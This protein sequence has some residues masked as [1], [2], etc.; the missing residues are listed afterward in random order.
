MAW[1]MLPTAKT[2]N[3]RFIASTVQKRK[4]N[5]VV[6]P[7]ALFALRFLQV[8]LAVFSFFAAGAAKNHLL[9]SKSKIGVRHSSR[10]MVFG[11]AGWLH[12]RR[13]CDFIQAIEN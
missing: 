8:D 1:R 7:A 6:G 10:S 5:P 13:G 3:N 12:L 9:D 2:I 4:A 11:E